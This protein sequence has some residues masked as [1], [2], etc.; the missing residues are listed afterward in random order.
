LIRRNIKSVQVITR[1]HGNV[2]E[3]KSG[4]VGIGVWR[5]VCLLS[6]AAL[7]ILKHGWVM[8]KHLGKSL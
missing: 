6:D 7:I 8:N 1:R 5:L 4:K 3:R 2:L